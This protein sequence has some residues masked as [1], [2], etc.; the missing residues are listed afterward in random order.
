LAKQ[1]IELY[2]QIGR[3]KIH[4]PYVEGCDVGEPWFHSSQE[5]KSSQRKETIKNRGVGGS[6]EYYL[7]VQGH[8]EKFGGDKW[9]EREGKWRRKGDDASKMAHPSGCH[10]LND[11]PRIYLNSRGK[12]R[13]LEEDDQKVGPR[14]R[15][16][17][18]KG[19]D[20]GRY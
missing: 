8:S 16:D 2:E 1:R 10:T 19:G 11:K 18:K 4:T 20:P 7:G 9:G 14:D 6:K 15:H 17:G 12:P 3:E 5:A 13:Q